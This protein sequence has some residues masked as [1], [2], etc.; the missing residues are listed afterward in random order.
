MQQAADNGATMA[1]E[2]FRQ[3][4]RGQTNALKELKQI[5]RM[6]QITIDEKNELEN[7][8]ENNTD[9]VLRIQTKIIN[10]VK[11]KLMM[12]KARVQQKTKF[13]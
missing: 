11:T 7:L 13:F 1:S 6:S 12:L 10:E 2:K 4:L 3:D 5:L 9:E 8:T